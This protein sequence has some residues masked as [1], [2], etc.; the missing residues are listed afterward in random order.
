MF[1]VGGEGATFGKKKKIFSRNCNSSHHTISLNKNKKKM[2]ETFGGWHHVL[3]FLEH[4]R[5]FQF[6]R[7]SREFHRIVCRESGIL[8]NV[9]LRD[10]GNA[11]FGSRLLTVLNGLSQSSNIVDTDSKAGDGVNRSTIKPRRATIRFL[12]FR[13]CGNLTPRD[14]DILTQRLEWRVLHTLMWREDSWS[15]GRGRGMGNQVSFRSWFTDLHEHG[16]L[17]SLR[18]LAVDSSWQCHL[19]I[20]LGPGP[21]SS[22]SSNSSS[23]TSS[24][25]T[26]WSKQN[27]DHKEAENIDVP[28]VTLKTHLKRPNIGAKLIN[29]EF[30]G[31][32]DSDGEREGD[33]DVSSDLYYL[34]SQWEWYRTTDWFG[35][36]RKSLLSRSQSS[37]PPS[38]SSSSSLTSQ[39]S[40]QSLSSSPPLQSSS[41]SASLSA[42]SLGVL[43]SPLGAQLEEFI[44]YGLDDTSWFGFAD[45]WCLSLRMHPIRVMRKLLQHANKW[46]KLEVPMDREWSMLPPFPTS[47]FH[48]L[49]HLNLS[50]R[51]KRMSLSGLEYETK[52]DCDSVMALL[53]GGSVNLL[54]LESIV[55]PRL[56][57]GNLQ[58]VVRELAQRSPRL[59]VLVCEVCTRDTNNNDD[60]VDAHGFVDTTSIAVRHYIF[61]RHIRLTTPLPRDLFSRLSKLAIHDAHVLVSDI[62]TATTTSYPSLCTLT[63]DSLFLTHFDELTHLFSCLPNLTTTS[64]GVFQMQFTAVATPFAETSTSCSVNSADASKSSSSS[65]GSG[66]S[67]GSSSSSNS[68]S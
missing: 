37:S 17:R 24:A 42:F 7:C 32:S 53:L 64:I 6:A 60:P 59:S 38:Q 63:I 43:H 2:G 48:S 41:S 26:G 29:D 47:C 11:L 61:N 66:N 19:D 25:V 50:I 33:V 8:W 45:K 9:K 31:E 22:S 36:P 3:C 62:L 39:S 56:S 49:Q 35:V 21:G 34:M 44:L 20:L 27:V 40:S 1:M 55:L 4:R 16:R 51:G 12:D 23:S 68:S 15:F 10:H 13:R 30:E 65:N 57:S 18:R 28:N 58:L 67:S 5:V 46:Q 54:I 14:L 52:D